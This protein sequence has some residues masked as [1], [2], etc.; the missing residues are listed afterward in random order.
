MWAAVRRIPDV[1]HRPAVEQH[2]VCDQPIAGFK[3]RAERLGGEL[4][5]ATRTR[6]VPDV[7]H[8][9][10]TVSMKNPGELANLAR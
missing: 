8:C 1:R 5:V 3:G 2:H 9:L 6:K 10:D 4:K 7:D